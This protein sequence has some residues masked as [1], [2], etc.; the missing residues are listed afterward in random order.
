MGFSK[1]R[2]IISIIIAIVVF[3]IVG[4]IA[5]ENGAGDG[6]A[7]AFA[8]PAALLVIITL[9]P[10][11]LSQTLWKFMLDRIRELSKAIQGKE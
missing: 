10:K 5:F 2:L 6:G 4:H 9:T 7:F 1:I 11:K 3:F 8:I